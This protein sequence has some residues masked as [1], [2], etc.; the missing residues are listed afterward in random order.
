MRGTSSQCTGS[1][2]VPPLDQSFWSSSL[3]LENITLIRNSNI[4]NHKHNSLWSFSPTS[5]IVVNSPPTIVACR[6]HSESSFVH[7][8]MTTGCDATLRAVWGGPLVSTKTCFMLPWCAPC[9]YVYFST[10]LVNDNKSNCSE[11]PYDPP[12]RLQIDFLSSV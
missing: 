7:S 11:L 4:C 2:V 8:T 1:R 9:V 10:L 6:S 3:K 5:P 12:G